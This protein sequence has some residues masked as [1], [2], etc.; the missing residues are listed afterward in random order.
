MTDKQTEAL[1]L[2]DLFER[3]NQMYPEQ[4]TGLDVAAELRRLHA[5][6]EELKRALVKGHGSILGLS[7][8]PA[9]SNARQSL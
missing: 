1:R 7:E 4:R 9:I 3:A 6:N 8:P 2:A 5:E